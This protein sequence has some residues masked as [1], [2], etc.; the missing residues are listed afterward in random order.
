MLEITEPLVSQPALLL[1]L[2][3]QAILPQE[4]LMKIIILLLLQLVGLVYFHNCQSI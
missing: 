2:G 3:I 4:Q 1:V